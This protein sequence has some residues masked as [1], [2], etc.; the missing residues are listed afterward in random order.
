MIA[1]FLKK[2]NLK[3]LIRNSFFPSPVDT[4]PAQYHFC[5]CFYIYYY[6]ILLYFMLSHYIIL[7]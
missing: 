3:E 7:Y 4:D 2:K 1:I 6:V 5:F